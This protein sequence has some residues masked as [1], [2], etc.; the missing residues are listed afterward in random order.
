MTEEEIVDIAER[1]LRPRLSAHGL[2]RVEASLGRDHDGDPAV[3]VVAHYGPG[4]DVPSGRELVEASGA[5]AAA[6]S[7]RGDTR[8]P[9]LDHRFFHEDTSFE[10]IDED[11]IGGVSQ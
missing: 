2:A 9:Y 5:L 8:Q 7:D 3:F 11:E 4:G 6:L 1:V 10:D